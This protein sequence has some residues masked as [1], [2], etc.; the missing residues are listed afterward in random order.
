MGVADQLVAAGTQLSERL[1]AL[2]FRSPV[3]YVYNPLEYASAPNHAY[4]RR[5]G[6]SKRRI[7]AFG[8]NPGPFGMAQTGVP[9]GEVSIVRDWLGITADVGRP[10][11]EHPKRLITG[12]ACTRSEVSGS[13]LWGAIRDQFV[14]PDAFFAEWFIVNYCPLVFMED[15]GRNRTPDKLPKAEREALFRACDEHLKAVVAAMEPEWLIGVGAFAG[16]RA[17]VCANSL[18]VKT[19]KILHPSP[20]NPLAN[21]DW[22]GTVRRQLADLGVCAADGKP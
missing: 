3:E 7:V 8:M 11:K 10:K 5:Y 17:D 22:E 1:G 4:L 13:R 6:D 9:F 2:T 21:R 16:K 20:A 12:F 19:G 18:G 15:S 14:E